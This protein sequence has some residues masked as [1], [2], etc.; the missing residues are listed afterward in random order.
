MINQ[1]PQPQ[2]VAVR[3][4]S[5]NLS[6]RDGGYIGMMT[7]CFTLVD[8]AQM[9]LNRRQGDSCDR[10]TNSHTSM[11]VGSRIYQDSPVLSLCTLNSVHQAAFMVGLVAFDQKPQIASYLAQVAIDSVQGG[12]AVCSGL[13]LPQQIQ[14][15]T[16]KD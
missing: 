5:T 4:K 3:A 15:R 2:I 6:N 14:V 16:V 10:I 8:V 12:E 1:R 9:H 7:E 13:T 11:G